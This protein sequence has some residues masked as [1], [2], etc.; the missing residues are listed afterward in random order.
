MLLV[1]SR[2][3]NRSV[4]ASCD[5]SSCWYSFDAAALAQHQ[6]IGTALQHRASAVSIIAALHWNSV[7]ASHCHSDTWTQHHAGAELQHCGVTSA[8][9]RVGAAG[10]HCVDAASFWCSVGATSR[11]VALAQCWAGSVSAQCRVGATLQH[12]PWGSEVL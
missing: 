11:F 9:C 3:R 7:V 5:A 1:A 2:W 10:Q 8:Q 4:A 6:D 12:L